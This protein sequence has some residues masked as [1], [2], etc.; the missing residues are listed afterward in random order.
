MSSAANLCS[1]LSLPSSACLCTRYIVWFPRSKP[2]LVI[3]RSFITLFVSF[4]SYSFCN[5]FPSSVSKHDSD[6]HTYTHCV[7]VF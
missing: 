1:V 4:V 3:I 2:L 5:R 7:S 6:T